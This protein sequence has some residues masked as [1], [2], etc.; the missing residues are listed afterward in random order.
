MTLVRLFE[1]S[2]CFSASIENQ[3]P[4]NLSEIAVVKFHTVTTAVAAV[5]NMHYSHN[6]LQVA[7]NLFLCCLS[8]LTV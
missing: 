2:Y 4:V 5:N 3:I 1:N 7:T 6:V 8:V